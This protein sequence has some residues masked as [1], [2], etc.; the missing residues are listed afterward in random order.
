MPNMAH[1]QVRMQVLDPMEAIKQIAH[2]LW[3]LKF[4]RRILVVWQNE[5]DFLFDFFYIIS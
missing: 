1:L 2:I 3:I 4:D 5:R